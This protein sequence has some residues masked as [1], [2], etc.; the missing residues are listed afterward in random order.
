MIEF[1]GNKMSA[2]EKNKYHLGVTGQNSMG[3][4]VHPLL[5]DPQIL[6]EICG[7]DPRRARHVLNQI[8]VTAC[9]RENLV[10]G[11]CQILHPLSSPV[12]PLLVLLLL[13]LGSIGLPVVLL[14]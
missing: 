7:G 4:L 13:L 11:F 10:D 14:Q 5:D 12:G 9:M 6:H 3:D 2:G 1:Q 8:R